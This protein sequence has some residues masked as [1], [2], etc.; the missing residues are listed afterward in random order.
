MGNL[1]QQ[2]SVKKPLENIVNNSYNQKCKDYP[3]T[4]I[5]KGFK[6]FSP[7]DTLDEIINNNKSIV[8]FGDGEF[9]IIFGRNIRFQ[10]KINYFQKDY[11]KY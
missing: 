9:K 5:L 7:E 1:Q 8:R 10:K 11:L 4:E 2:C 3:A 6:V